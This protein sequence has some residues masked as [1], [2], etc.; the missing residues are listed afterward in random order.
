M[1]RASDG[2]YAVA[3]AD[4]VA[5]AT[6]EAE[7][8][9]RLLTPIETSAH[10]FKDEAGELAAYGVEPAFDAKLARYGPGLIALRRSL[11]AGGYRQVGA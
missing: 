2:R 10:D 11:A 3:V 8:L 5:L 9:G 6:I 7:R 1:A 4:R